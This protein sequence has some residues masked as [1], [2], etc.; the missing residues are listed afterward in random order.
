MRVNAL[1]IHEYRL[2]GTS[3][4]K[5]K[6]GTY[7]PWVELEVGQMVERVELDAELNGV[8]I[9][10]GAVLALCDNLSHHRLQQ[11]RVHHHSTYKLQWGLLTPT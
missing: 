11:V 4:R 2:A 9:A 1:V 6:I 10:R 8:G 3:R 5:R 7:W